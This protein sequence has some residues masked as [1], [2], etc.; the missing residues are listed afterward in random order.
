MPALTR[1]KLAA[2]NHNPPIPIW[3]GHAK[4]CEQGGVRLCIRQESCDLA[5]WL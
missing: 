5:E 4:R 3:L 2:I 1:C